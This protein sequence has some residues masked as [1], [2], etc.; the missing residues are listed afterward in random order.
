MQRL[1]MARQKEKIPLKGLTKKYPWWTPKAPPERKSETEMI[2]VKSVFEGK[3][4]ILSTKESTA[5][6]V[7]QTKISSN[8]PVPSFAEICF[9]YV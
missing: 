7:C 6:G 8:V 9:A 1:H 5:R 4:T 2:E 3:S